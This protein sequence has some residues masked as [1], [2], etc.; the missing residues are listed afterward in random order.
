MIKTICLFGIG[1]S[2]KTT[3]L[4]LLANK[5]H[6]SSDTKDFDGNIPEKGDFKV[7]FKYKG[8]KVGIASGG[9]T[10]E[11]V[12]NNIEFFLSKKCKILIIAARSKG[13]SHTIIYDYCD[14]HELLWLRQRDIW[15]EKANELNKQSLYKTSNKQTTDLIISTMNMV[16]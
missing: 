1:N 13:D 10:A 8:I 9:D 2:G 6:S 4:R 5:L 11:V 12:K 16:S 7:C 3:T 14:E 15:L